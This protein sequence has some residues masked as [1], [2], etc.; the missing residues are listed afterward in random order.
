MAKRLSRCN[1]AT[2]QIGRFARGYRAAVARDALRLFEGQEL[3]VTAEAG[4]ITYAK[5]SR[6]RRSKYRLEELLAQCDFNIP[7][8]EEE[9]AWLNAPPVGREIL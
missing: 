7:L 9:A 3:T 4:R 2:T 8:S 1:R 6:R 5:T